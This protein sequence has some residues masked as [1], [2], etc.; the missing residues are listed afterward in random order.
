MSRADAGPRRRFLAPEVVQTS[1]MDCGPAALKCLLDGLGRPVSYG[2][3][4]EACQTDVDGT[5]I[6]TLEEVAQQLGLEAEQVVQ[7]KDHVLSPALSNL[8]ALVVTRLPTGATHFA[9]AWRRTAGLVQVM[10]P[11]VGRRWTSERAFLDELYQHRMPVP[12]HE[13]RSWADSDDF[14]APLGVRLRAL[15]LDDAVCQRL[16]AEA[17]ADSGWVGLGALD[18]ATRLA[19]DLVETGG[20][21]RDAT[22]A[23]LVEELA[24]QARAEALG[25]RGTVPD[26]CWSVRPA[27]PDDDGTPRVSIQG[28][29]LVRVRGVGAPSAASVEEGEG[30]RPLSPELVAALEEKPPHPLRTLLALVRKDGLL[31]PAVLAGAL[32]VAASAVV[33]E[34]LLYRALVDLGWQ[35]GLSGERLVALSALGVFVL[36]VSGLEVALVAGLLGGGRRLENRLRLAFLDKL[37]RLPHRYFQSRLTSDMA[38]RSH[39]AWSL[40][41][42]PE[43]GGQALLVLA[44]LLATTAGIS[45]L[46]PASATL[47]LLAAA[48]AVGLPLLF[49]PAIFERD[50]RLRTHTGAL[51][52]FYLDAMLGLTPVRVHAAESAMRSE[53]DRLLAEWRRAAF[54]L[55]RLLVSVETLQL[56]AGFGLAGWLLHRH[57]SQ[58]AQPAAALLLVYWAL[59]LPLLGQAL[60]L[61]LRQYAHQR[62]LTLRLLEPLGAPEDDDAPGA[63]IA[64]T[65]EQSPAPNPAHESQR[66]TGV[67]LQLDRVT[68]HAGGHVLLEEVSLALVPGEHVAVLGPSG[69]GKS[70]LLGLLLG[71]HRAAAGQVLV[72]GAPLDGARL[73][74]LR[75][76]TAWVDPA[77]QLWNRSLLDN[78]RYGLGETAGRPLGDVVEQAELGS[79]LQTLEDGLGTSLGEGGAR[80]SG[81]Q[82]QR[83]RLGRG[84]LRPAPR[85]V[86]LDE[87]FR[88][89]DR[90]QR[91]RLLERARRVWAGATLV[92]V[93]HDVVETAS[94]PRV[95]LIDRGRLVEDGAPGVLRSEPESRYAQLLARE[96]R[97]RTELWGSSD[98]RRL[99]LVGG[100]L[101]ERPVA[102]APPLEGERAAEERG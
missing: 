99:E 32:V 39:S 84:L 36:L 43:Q 62:T 61:Y 87:A 27:A 85:L 101:V 97:L 15:G 48:A 75:R 70:S 7:P 93:T 25:E 17:R 49:R 38:E 63:A 78:L 77:V 23:A 35:L 92:C 10:D 83:V 45:W 95:L 59:E 86:L 34:A 58:A 22:L 9:V 88:G 60:A 82:G 18:A 19:A 72:D 11:A 41:R 90:E 2:R 81:G 42:V 73:R 44:Q 46:D 94:F 13:W 53:H 79:V 16:L 65:P 96:E 98:W 21:S 30:P 64:P 91:R 102:G 4:R 52:R 89:L 26:A 100:R 28:A 74:R 51:G 40:R 71:W 66:A 50:L 55:L 80:V 14:L 8:P 68:V 37:A 56:L 67:A 31:R 29:V 3:L 20:L 5:S 12:E 54:S 47:A 33:L 69:A 24:A 57:L 76:E 1:A 6:D